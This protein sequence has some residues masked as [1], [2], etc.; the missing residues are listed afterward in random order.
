MHHDLLAQ[1]AELGAEGGHAS[2][3][4]SEGENGASRRAV[5]STA[6]LTE[7]QIACL[8][9]VNEHLTSK[10]IGLCLGISN[11]TV[12]QRVRQALRALGCR[13]RRD[14]AKLIGQEFTTPPAAQREAPEQ[15]LTRL[16]FATRRAPSN[17]LSTQ[18]RMM[19]IVVIAAGSALSMALYLAG[20]ESLV[21][22]LGPN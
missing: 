20:L 18:A 13:T 1:P 7:G 19:W 5:H 10:E 4:R 6:R 3:R 8:L 17:N 22:M 12:D 9:L 21:R 15:R 2:R 16:P 11:H 14:A